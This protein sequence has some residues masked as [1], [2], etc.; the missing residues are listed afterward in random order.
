MQLPTPV[1]R[2]AR[3]FRAAR[4]SLAG[5]AAFLLAH[6]TRPF[7]GPAPNWT[8]YTIVAL[9]LLLMGSLLANVL[10]LVIFIIAAYG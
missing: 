1:Y 6:A 3:R 9:L 10:F 8:V 4:R 5:R 7:D 2:Y